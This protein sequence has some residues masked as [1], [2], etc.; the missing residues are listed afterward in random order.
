MNTIDAASVAAYLHGSAA[1]FA[2]AGA[3]ISAQDV[4]NSW[5]SAVRALSS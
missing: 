1:R 4:L 5:P 2:A 3:S